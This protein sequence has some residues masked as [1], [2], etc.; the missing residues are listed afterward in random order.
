[1]TK[2]DTRH[3]AKFIDQCQYRRVGKERAAAQTVEPPGTGEACSPSILAAPLAEHEAVELAR[4]FAALAEPARLRLFSLIA[5][6]PEGEVCACALVEPLRRSQPTVSHHLK[7]LYEAGLV[8]RQKRGNWVWYWV[9][10]D[11]L[12]ALRATLKATPPGSRFSPRP[13]DRL[14]IDCPTS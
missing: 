14:L 4:G 11:R 9:V 8:D 12:E 2:V 10:P 13:T 7:V 1:L 5:A 6:Q 3:L